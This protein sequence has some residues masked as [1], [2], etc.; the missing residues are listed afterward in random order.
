MNIKIL[1]RGQEFSF[2]LEQKNILI[3]ESKI[4]H[5]FGVKENQYE[6]FYA[7]IDGENTL[8]DD[9]TDFEEY[10]QTCSDKVV[11]C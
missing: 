11:V 8:I 6:L 7:D 5:A 9:Q 3:L 4:N 2:F 1:F 10:L